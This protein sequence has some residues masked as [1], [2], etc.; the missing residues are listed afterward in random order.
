MSDKLTKLI[1]E[2][3]EQKTFS[4]DALDSIKKLRD[5]AQ[6]QESALKFKDEMLD[7]KKTIELTIRAEMAVQA[8]QLATWKTREDE[9]KKRE[10]TMTALEKSSAIADAKATSYIEFARLVF[11]NRITREKVLHSTPVVIPT[12]GGSYTTVNTTTEDVS[13]EDT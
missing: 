5:K 1:D 3:I 4:L 9:L 6:E 10:L 2:I 11:A 8:T 13:R 12:P 7:A